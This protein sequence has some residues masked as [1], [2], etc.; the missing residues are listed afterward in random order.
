M[1]TWSIYVI[2]C[3]PTG[4]QY[5]G[6]TRRDYRERFGQHLGEART[7]DWPLSRAIRQFGSESFVV[8]IV[9][10]CSSHEAA[11]EREVS[12]IADLNTVVP[13]GFNLTNGGGGLLGVQRSLEWRR[14][15]SATLKVVAANGRRWG[16]NSS[17]GQ[18]A[19]W[20]LLSPAQR[21]ARIRKAWRTRSGIAHDP[22][23][24]SLL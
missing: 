10:R 7:K 1:T 4:Q 9:D 23:Q 13:N 22:R 3:A 18:K 20:S 11:C 6:Q 24:G 12:L 16:T 17:A 14:K 19:V 15:H 5:V 8:E 21:S 2:T